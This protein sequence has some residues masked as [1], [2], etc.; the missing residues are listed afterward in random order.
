[1]LDYHFDRKACFLFQTHLPRDETTEIRVHI[2]HEGHV[3]QREACLHSRQDVCVACKRVV[4]SLRLP[5]WHTSRQIKE[6]S[7]RNFPFTVR[8]KKE[9]QINNFEI[10]TPL[11]IS[12]PLLTTQSCKQ[13]WCTGKSR[14]YQ[15]IDMSSSD[16]AIYSM[17][18]DKV[19]VW[20]CNTVCRHR[21]QC[22]RL[23]SCR[24]WGDTDLG[25]WALTCLW[26]RLWYRSTFRKPW[27]RTRWHIK[28]MRL[29]TWGTTP[30]GNSDCLTEIFCVFVNETT[31]II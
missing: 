5:P 13:I 16:E 19:D 11:R 10:P 1:M 2:F 30:E 18:S 7:G 23:S 3:E 17:K 21:A 26:Q 4:S 27:F 20:M 29:H 14:M 15:Y 8:R 9:D 31:Q 25:S 6:K 22:R 24:S 28:S 12:S